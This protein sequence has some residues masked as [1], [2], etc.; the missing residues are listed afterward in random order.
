M[1]GRQDED[2]GGGG[3][4]TLSSM[5]CDASCRRRMGRPTSP[6]D[7]CTVAV[8][9]SRHPLLAGS[10]CPVVVGWYRTARQLPIQVGANT[11]TSIH[12][13]QTTALP[14][15]SPRKQRDKD[16]S[17]ECVLLS[18]SR[19]ALEYTAFAV[20]L[21]PCFPMMQGEIKGIGTK[22]EPRETTKLLER[23]RCASH[24]DELQHDEVGRRGAG[25]HLN[26]DDYECE[27]K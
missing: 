24:I 5:P 2:I 14:A 15:A 18:F 23:G 8:S 19:S 25:F 17:V 4:R 9:G 3:I 20:R 12:G 1:Y 16:C 22:A 7:L 27:R 21:V 26:Q 11:R 10:P 6:K 13:E